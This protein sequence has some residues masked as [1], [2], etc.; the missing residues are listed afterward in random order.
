MAS[1]RGGTM[2]GTS[3]GPS[4]IEAGAGPVVVIPGRI[5][6]M[7]WSYDV[8]RS[9]LEPEG[10]RLVVPADDAAA[11]E[12]LRTADVVFTSSPLRAA[13]IARFENC[14]GIVCYSVGMDYVDIAAA[15]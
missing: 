12:A 13:D 14:A 5:R 2:T 8:E 6:S 4:A 7:S 11:A 15:A 1:E 3:P 10:V 9:I